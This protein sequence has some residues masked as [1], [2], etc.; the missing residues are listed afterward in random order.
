M[1]T[2]CPMSEPPEVRLPPTDRWWLDPAAA[3]VGGV[4]ALVTRGDPPRIFSTLARHP[5]L[6]YR[7]LPFGSAFLFGSELPRGDVELAILRTAWNCASRYEYAQHVALAERTGLGKDAI[8]RVPKGPAASGWTSRQ[9][10]LLRATDELHRHRVIS[11]PTWE[12]LAAELQPRQLIELCLLVGHYEMLAMTLNSLGVE[13]E[14]S[15]LRRLTGRTVQA[16]ESLRG[17]LERVRRP[18]SDVTIDPGKQDRRRDPM[19]S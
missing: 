18:R 5:L 6:F 3:F 2:I 14:P 17:R 10:L 7:W 4:S 12:A 9:A 15:A 8:E 19:A 1:R 13:P 11:D 16:A